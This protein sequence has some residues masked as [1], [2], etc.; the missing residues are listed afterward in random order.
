[1]LQHVE[2]FSEPNLRSLAHRVENQSCDPHVPEFQGIVEGASQ[3][4]S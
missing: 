1:M 2:E 3:C 4:D